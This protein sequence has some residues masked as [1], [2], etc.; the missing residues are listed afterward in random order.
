M[1]RL[2][3][4]TRAVSTASR[5]HRVSVVVGSGGRFG[6]VNRELSE[7]AFKVRVVLE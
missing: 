7:V 4:A 6:L 5:G 2:L 3:V 1:R